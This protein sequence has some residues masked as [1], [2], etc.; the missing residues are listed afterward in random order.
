MKV[1]DQSKLKITIFIF[2][3]GFNCF[4]FLSDP[5]KLVERLFCEVLNI[6]NSISPY[7]ASA[8]PSLLV[9]EKLQNE[10]ELLRK[11][12]DRLQIRNCFK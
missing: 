9:F 1:L 5:L 3:I 11:T 12:T 2:E 4:A 10:N 8:T 7:S 6:K